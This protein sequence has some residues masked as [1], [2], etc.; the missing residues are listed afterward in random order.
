[1]A[2]K[3][4]LG[5]MIERGYAS[6]GSMNLQDVVREIQARYG[7]DRKAAAAVGVHHRTWQRWR[8]GEAK[9]NILHLLSVGTAVRKV[10][11]ESRPFD[12][13]GL[14]LKTTGNDGR[15]R[16][17]HGYQLGFGQAQSAAIEGAYIAEGADAAARQFMTELRAT[18]S[19]R[20]WYA[21]Y[22]DPLSRTDE[23]E[24]LFD[25]AVDEPDDMDAYSAG[26][27]SASW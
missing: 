5:R 10:R 19:G 7:S 21:E 26:S 18:P 24:D 27:G 8:K 11:A 22:L 9:P 23:E 1:M 13:A 2:A 25:F 16:K 14:I 20:D 12:A 17:I 15:N 6:A 4:Q 3:S